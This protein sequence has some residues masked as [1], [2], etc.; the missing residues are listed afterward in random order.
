MHYLGFY[1]FVL[2]LIVSIGHIGNAFSIPLL[3]VELP[4]ISVLVFFI[5][6]GFVI[7]QGISLFYISKPINFLL[8]RFL[9]IFP[10]FI[11]ALFFSI[12]LHYVVARNGGVSINFGTPQNIF[13]WLNKSTVAKNFVSII[14]FNTIFGS[15]N[16]YLFVRYIWSISVEFYFYL[17]MFVLMFFGKNYHFTFLVFTILLFFLDI[18]QKSV[19]LFFVCFALGVSIHLIMKSRFYFLFFIF[20]LFILFSILT[21][22][23]KIIMISFFILILLLITLI[24]FPINN[25]IFKI[26]KYLGQLSYPLFL[27]HYSFEFYFSAFPFKSK[28]LT[29]F[30]AIIFSIFFA[31]FASALIETSTKRIRD[32]IRHNSNSQL[33]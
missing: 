29:F 32:R 25:F 14:D 33:N 26:D 23:E 21:Q 7:S 16:Y 19:L 15:E 6:S 13:S 17:L 20:F 28:L 8:N 9:R 11:L 10:P 4:F 24:S 22:T 2:A 5:L 18:I 27:N 12:L 3:F 31:A 30:F 1:R